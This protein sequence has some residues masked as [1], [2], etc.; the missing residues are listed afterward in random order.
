[1][2][3]VLV[4]GGGFSSSCWDLLVPNLEG[5]VVGVDLPGRG[6]RPADLAG[7]TLTDYVDAIVDDI[8]TAGLDDV[9]LVGHSAAGTSLPGVALRIPERLRRLVFVSCMVPDD[10]TSAHDTLSKYLAPEVGEQARVNAERRTTQAGSDAAPLDMEVARRW[11]ANDMDEEQTQFMLSRLVPEPL[12]TLDQPVD[13]SGVAAVPRTWVRLSRDAVLVPELQ[14]HF[15]ANIGGAEVVELDAGHMAMI[16]RPRELAEIL[17][18][19]AARDGAS[20]SPA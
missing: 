14:D 13:L 16:S 20:P 6:V 9:I 17:N 18:A 11:F 4:H 1:M 15:I 5:D 10:G 8:T 19:I 2:T 12:G 3:F 7:V